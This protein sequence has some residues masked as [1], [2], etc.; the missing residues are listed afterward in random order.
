[1]ITTATLEDIDYIFKISS[2]FTDYFKN[3][4]DIENIINSNI[5]DILVYKLNNQIIGFVHILSTIDSIDLINI[6]VDQEHRN[7]HIGTNLL[8]YVIINNAIKDN[9]NI[10]LEVKETN[11]NAIKL[12]EN[13]EFKTIYVRK[14]YYKDNTNC[15]VMKYEVGDKMKK[16]TIILALESS[17][18]ETS[19][20]IVKNGNEDIYSVVYSQIPIHEKFGGVKPEIAS[21][22][23]LLKILDVIDEIEE[24]SPLK[25]KDVD[26]IAVTYGPGLT[27]SLLISIEAAKT[28]SYILNKP[29]LPVHH[30]IGHIYSNAITSTLKFPLI[31]LV[32][33][34]GHSDIIKMDE[35]YSFTKIGGTLD[36]AVGEAYDK[37]AKILGLSYPGGPIIDKLAKLGNDTYNLPIPLDDDSSDFSFSGIKSAV[38]NLVNNEKQ[39]GNEIRVNDMACSFQNRVITILVKKTFRELEKHNINNLIIA[40]GVSANSTLRNTL[41]LKSKEKNINLILPDLKYCTDNATMIGAAAYYGIG[42][43]QEADLTLESKSSESYI[44]TG[45]K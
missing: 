6:G 30:I 28:M 5:D 12:Y 2:T 14:Q 29:L 21:R 9:K 1:M 19:I 37:V 7:K 32:I 25:I 17:C 20:S 40:G 22:N 45:G 39:R 27:G 42:K 38:I 4:I 3:K 23:H 16:D 34:G 15:L 10:F 18:D 8:Q 33:S 24:K 35:H 44:N 43:I 13:N 11:I 26:Y 31:A 36:D 41:I